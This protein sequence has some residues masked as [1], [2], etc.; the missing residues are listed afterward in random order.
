M[1]SA[2]ISVT[3]SAPEDL[4]EIDKSAGNE[5]TLEGLLKD[6]STFERI[7]IEFAMNPGYYLKVLA[8]VM[9]P[10]ILIAFWASYELLKQAEGVGK[11]AGGR[12]KQ[13]KDSASTAKRAGMRRR[14]K[15]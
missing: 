8:L 14:V 4:G 3:G 6:A 7:M 2:G 15:R 13:R 11:R 9:S 12:K 5:D 10:M 1:E